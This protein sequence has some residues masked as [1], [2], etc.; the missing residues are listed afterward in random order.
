VGAIRPI[1]TS[2]KGYRFRSRLE[3]RWAVFFHAVEIEWEYEVEGFH[4]PD[5]QQYLPDFWL[6]R[7]KLFVEVKPMRAMMVVSHETLKCRGLATYDVNVLILFGTPGPDTYA[8]A[9]FSMDIFGEDDKGMAQCCDMCFGTEECR[10]ARGAVN[11]SNL[12]LLCDQRDGGRICA[13]CLHHFPYGDGDWSSPDRSSL[14]AA[15]RRARSARFEFGET[16]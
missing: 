11:E 1:E 13:C 8:A 12:W 9:F 6:P 5:G 15:Y 4:L 7:H 10:F 16:G 14:Q 2:Y 3:A